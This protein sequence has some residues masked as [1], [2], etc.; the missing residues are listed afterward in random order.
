VTTECRYPLAAQVLQDV[1]GSF[2]NVFTSAPGRIVYGDFLGL[3]R[4][5]LYG[6]GVLVSSDAEVALRTNLGDNY[7]ADVLPG[8][9]HVGAFFGT[10]SPVTTPDGNGVLVIFP[11][12]TAPTLAT[13]GTVTLYVDPAT[14]NLMGIG[15]SGVPRVIMLA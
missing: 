8:N 13:V 11:A 1:G 10:A 14:G 2:S 15:T 4:S 5:E 3:V 6:R 7:R 9:R 12:T